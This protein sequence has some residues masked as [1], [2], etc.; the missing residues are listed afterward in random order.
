MIRKALKNIS[1]ISTDEAINLENYLDAIN[2]IDNLY[3]VASVIKRYIS[4]KQ[5]NFLPS[6]KSKAL[7]EK[8]GIQSDPDENEMRVIKFSSEAFLVDKELTT[9]LITDLEQ[10]AHK[11]VLVDNTIIVTLKQD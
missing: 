3:H 5:I 7:C 2:Y 10:I 9:K 1:D 6:F 11:I 4:I 8:L